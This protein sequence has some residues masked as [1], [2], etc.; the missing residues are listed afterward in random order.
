MSAHLLDDAGTRRRVAGTDPARWVLHPDFW[1]GQRAFAFTLGASLLGCLLLA[2]YTYGGGLGTLLSLS[3]QG[4]SVWGVVIAA[5]GLAVADVDLA[6]AGEMEVRGT[7]YLSGLSSGGESAMDLDRL[8]RTLAPNNTASPP[9]S[10]LRIFQQICKE[11]RDRRFESA[12]TLVQPYRDEATEDVFRL[13]TLQKI[14]LW[15]GILGTFV[16]LLMALRESRGTAPDGDAALLARV[17]EMYDGLFISF[18][19]SVAGLEVAIILSAALLLL[20]KS[21]ERCFAVMEGTAVTLLSAAR[22][23]INHDDFIQEFA[24]V[25]TTVRELAN[26]VHQQ[27]RDIADR[28]N[29]VELRLHDQNERIDTGLQ[30]LA[31]AQD[32]FDRF[33]R[34]V[35]NAEHRFLTDLAELFEAASFRDLARTLHE[36]TREVGEQ[37]AGRL[38]ETAGRSTAQMEAFHLSVK[39]LAAAVQAQLAGFTASVD[40]LE[41][42]LAAASARSAEAVL[43]A[44]TRLGQGDSRDNAAV[45]ELLASRIAELDRT[46]R[47]LAPRRTRGLGNL[48]VSIA[49]RWWRHGARHR[50]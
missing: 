10:P 33:L 4:L 49:P 48:L 29:G 39:E 6:L 14:A 21:Q 18:T 15:L 25:N 7:A 50:G 8:E 46:L 17:Q 27:T 40:R 26:R 34:N 38:D 9:P 12:S 45:L 23:A 16:G 31:G 36:G 30:R 42:R 43:T 20:R 3:I 5:R 44:C 11:A 32:E 2:P 13:Q 24:T 28:L 19:A 22:H 47:R 41:S 35:S 1:R 37:L